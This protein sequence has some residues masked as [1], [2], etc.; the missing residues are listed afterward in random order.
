[1]RYLVVFS[2]TPVQAFIAKARKLRDFYVSSRI[3]SYLASVGFDSV[4][5]RLYPSANSASVP[6][7]FVF[8]IDVNS[9]E[10]VKNE[11][12]KIE[13]K[14]QDEWLKLADIAKVPRDIVDDY[15]QYS[16]AAVLYKDGEYKNAHSKVQ[17]L[18]AATKLKPR[19]IRKTQKGEKCPLCG[20]NT[21]WHNDF[22]TDKK[23][24][25]CGVCAIKRKLPEVSIPVD[26]KL[27]SELANIKFDSTTR[28][29]AYK[30]IEANGLSEE[31]DKLH[32]G[33]DDKLPNKQRYYALLL[34][35]GDKMGDLVNTKS[36]HKEHL[37]LSEKLDQFCEKIK[38]IEISKYAGEL[39]YAGGDDVCAILSLDCAIETARKIR[40]SYEDIVTKTETSES[41]KKPTS[42][43]A[44]ILIAHHKEPLREVIRDAHKLLD[45]VAK[46]KAGRD[47][48]AIKLK[49]RS[50][51][52]R[53]LYFKWDADNNKFVGEKLFDSLN[54]VKNALF[55]NTLSSSLV[56]RL[57][58]LK[59][60][61]SVEGITDKQILK[62]FEYEVAHS[63][64]KENAEINA[65]RLA[66]ICFAGGSFNP[67][68][69]VIA[70]FL[71]P[72]KENNKTEDNK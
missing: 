62:L 27:R 10:E 28:I 68:A 21:V 5:E 24:K 17:S 13:A 35:D 7:K 70:R 50:G 1:M 11:M 37:A 36:D 39:I 33:N 51:G 29:S 52:D 30:Y 55:D 3:L 43:S 15:W 22:G 59:E 20:E 2:I 32:E 25:L 60:A 9:V 57:A 14:I 48:L 56:Y 66:G 53:E 46:E 67:E 69:A 63:I 47:A 45:S 26:H 61:I 34:M 40:D 41:D 12:A 72:E 65:K 16:W 49:K 8:T 58:Q 64:G 71:A 4:K 38:K 31:V 6:N 42:I 54:E 18:L 44:A 23:E 19:K